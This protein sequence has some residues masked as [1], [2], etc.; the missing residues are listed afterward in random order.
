MLAKGIYVCQASIIS[1]KIYIGD[2][3]RSGY[4]S[5]KAQNA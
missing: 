1:D 2:Y 3:A 5:Y 4:K